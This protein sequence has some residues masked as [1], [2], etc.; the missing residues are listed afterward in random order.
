MSDSDDDSVPPPPPP[1]ALLSADKSQVSEIKLS[2]NS[3]NLRPAPPPPMAN[4]NQALNKDVHTEKVAPPVRPQ[5]KATTI[6][7]AAAPLKS[8]QNGGNLLFSILDKMET[9]NKF[10]ESNVSHVTEADKVKS[11]VM[12]QVHAYE[13]E[14]KDKIGEF[15][16]NKELNEI[17]IDTT[18]DPQAAYIIHDTVT[19]EFPELVSTS[20]GTYDDRRVIV[21]RK[22]YQPQEL[23]LYTIEGT[24]TKGSKKS[25]A[26]AVI[27]PPPELAAR[28]IKVNT[29]KR[30]RREVSDIIAEK[31]KK[32]KINMS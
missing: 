29:V 25:S 26:S 12:D 9:T 10:R 27:N 30:D 2:E 28:L 3:T 13:S 5:L 6:T 23:T 19:N 32:R 14:I 17:T 21:Y 15:L 20:V 7:A 24:I 8:K 22:G 11:M 16:L 4:R 18:N 31:E 1:P